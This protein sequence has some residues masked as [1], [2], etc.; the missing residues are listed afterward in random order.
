[1][2]VTGLVSMILSVVVPIA[3]V[4]GMYHDGGTVG[5]SPAST[6]AFWL[7]IGLFF[8]GLLTL[9][10]GVFRYATN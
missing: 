3:G 5:G 1:M 10:I 7:M 2:I 9:I 4:F 6:F 8:G